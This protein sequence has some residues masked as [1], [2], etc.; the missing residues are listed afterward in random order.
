MA[1]TLLMWL[2][3]VRTHPKYGLPTPPLVALALITLVAAPWIIVIA[4]HDYSHS[5]VMRSLSH[6][7][8]TLT[9]EHTTTPA[10]SAF[11]DTQA[12]IGHQTLSPS[13]GRPGYFSTGDMPVTYTYTKDLPTIMRF[14]QTMSSRQQ[15][16]AIQ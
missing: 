3:G 13:L 8:P 11:Y 1:G 2:S 16:L 6:Y 12:S 5:G 7:I 10:P 14:S 9:Y 4:I 15:Q